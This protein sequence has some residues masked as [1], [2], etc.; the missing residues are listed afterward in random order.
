MTAVVDHPGP[1]VPPS[2]VVAKAGVGE[3]PSALMFKGEPQS[4]VTVA[5]VVERLHC[6]I[7]DGV[8]TAMNSAPS[9]VFKVFIINS[10]V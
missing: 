5:G 7:T 4:T 1:I 8:N 3:S 6:A 2:K 10:V 9:I